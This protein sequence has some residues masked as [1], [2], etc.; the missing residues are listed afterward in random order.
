M[1]TN[2][3]IKFDDF[4]VERLKDKKE[5]KAFLDA[6]LEEYQQDNNFEAF[7]NALELLIR[8][9]GNISEFTKKANID[10]SHIYKIMKNE[11]QPQF[12]TVSK[13]LNSLGFQLTVK[14]IKHKPA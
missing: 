13:I 5:A 4:L 2:R 14:K 1:V 7:A 9:Q 6:I 8:A 11:T 3:S 10:R 12:L